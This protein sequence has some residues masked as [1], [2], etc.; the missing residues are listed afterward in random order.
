MCEL[1]GMSANTPTDIVFSVTGLI[2]RGGRTGP[3]RDGWGIAFYEGKGC[4]LFRDPSASTDSAVARFV[5][6]YPIKSEVVISHIR[7]A[8][9]GKI[10]LANTHPFVRELWG[11]MW[12]FAHNGQLKGIKKRGL[13]FYKPVGTTDS[14]HAFCWLLDRIREQFPEPPQK[15]QHLHNYV[16]ELGWELDALGVANFLLSDS[17]YLYAHCST[18]M[19]WITRR[20]PFGA[21]KLIDTEVEIDFAT[22]T[23]DKDIVTVVATQPLTDNEAWQSME[24]GELRVFD[25]GISQRLN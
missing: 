17:H 19:C 24:N 21:A 14:E 23:T 10:C 7:R 4:R 22:E 6:N 5:K 13:T 8:N 3:H 12:C 9:R 18:R 20:A 25:K 16:A 11:R 15:R 2:E 1:L